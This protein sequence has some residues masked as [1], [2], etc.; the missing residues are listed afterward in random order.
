[1]KKL[2][3]F[4]AVFFITHYGFSQ[5]LTGLWNGTFSN[6]ST[7]LRKD[8]PFEIAL[9]EYRGKVYGYSRREFIKNDTLYF[10]LKRVKGKI[11]GDV[12][13]VT[14]DEFISHN[15]PTID[16]GVKITYTFHFNKNDST[17]SLDG[18]WK[19]NRVVKRKYEYYALTGNVGMNMEKDL[20]K[21]KLFPHLAELKLDEDVPFYASYKHELKVEE[22][23]RK[24]AAARKELE[25]KRIAMAKAEQK[26]QEEKAAAQLKARQEA[27]AK[28]VAKTADKEKPKEQTTTPATVKS[29]TPTDT[30]KDVTK[31]KPEPEKKKEEV[32]VQKKEP[33][34]VAPAATTNKPKAD[35]TTVDQKNIA[36]TT[37][38]PEKKKEDIVKK[39]VVTVTPPDAT[40]NK[41]K[42]KT[43]EAPKLIAAVNVEKRKS[44]TIQFIEFKSDSL[45]LALYDNGEI[46]GDTVSVLINGEVIMPKQG[47]KASAIK[48]TVYITPAI[49]DSFTLVLYAENLGLY[50]PNTGLIIVRDGEDSYQVR[51]SADL[52]KNV[53]VL[54]KR[55]KK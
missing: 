47:L 1:M 42:E 43:D 12:C 28:D 13:E 33:V 50:P 39:E 5:S 49:Q 14:E 52:Q 45:I 51:F 34:T 40:A 48:K 46:D 44:E 21:S 18:K 53:A 17:W 38:E 3:V 27:S 25:D 24:I 54:F 6:D 31:S 35:T 55:K 32:V 10:V 36:K 2:C 19:T 23:Q 29:I 11:D 30:Q 20:S 9:T 15:L 8:Q 22:E 16:K 4:I 7:T 41:P 37:T 26:K